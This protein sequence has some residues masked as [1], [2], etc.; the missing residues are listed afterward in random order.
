MFELH[1][2]ENWSNP[3]ENLD[4][5]GLLKAHR[6]RLKIG[7]R[8]TDAQP[9]LDCDSMLQLVSVSNPAYLSGGPG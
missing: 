9:V 2:G 7:C 6:F 4:W 8:N 5:H 1:Y 3:L